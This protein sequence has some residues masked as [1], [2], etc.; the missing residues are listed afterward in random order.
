MGLLIQW[1]HRLITKEFI[2]KL[3]L[4]SKGI[5][6]ESAWETNI[7]CTLLS[8]FSLG[9]FHELLVD[10]VFFSNVQVWTS[11][12]FFLSFYIFF[13]NNHKRVRVPFHNPNLKAK[14][15]IPWSTWAFIG[16]VSWSGVRGLRKKALER[17][18]E[19]LRVILSKNLKSVACTFWVTLYSFCLIH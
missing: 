8:Q 10:W 1:W 4:D 19:C 13:F 16:F 12:V 5:P 6:K 3:P 15:V 7:R 11:G 9:I 2:T 14:L 18:K 17:L